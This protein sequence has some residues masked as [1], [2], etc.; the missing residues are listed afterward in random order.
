MCNRGDCGDRNDMGRAAAEEL[1]VLFCEL[2]PSVILLVFLLVSAAI[3]DENC[4][5][6][7]WLWY[8]AI[9][10]QGHHASPSQATRGAALLP[11][12]FGLADNAGQPIGQARAR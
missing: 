1:A 8:Y 3:D 12:S 6:F 7:N 9:V 4:F 5:K 10:G 11:C 2:I